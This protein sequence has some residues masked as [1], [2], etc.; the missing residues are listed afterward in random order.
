MYVCI[1]VCM[2]VYSDAMSS[3]GQLCVRE[4]ESAQSAR[5]ARV[6]VRERES[7]RENARARARERE[8]VPS[9]VTSSGGQLR[10]ASA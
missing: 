3:G 7:E 4:G 5:E 9:E 1:Y 10:V 8:R 2:Y 6:C